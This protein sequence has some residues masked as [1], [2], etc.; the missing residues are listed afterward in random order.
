[1]PSSRTLVLGAACAGAVVALLLLRKRLSA[2]SWT[3]QDQERV[4]AHLE[5]F[6][7][8][9]SAGTAPAAGTAGL[10]AEE[11]AFIDAQIQKADEEDMLD[12]ARQAAY[13]P[14]SGTTP[15]P[16]RPKGKGFGKGK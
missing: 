3:S 12:D 6:A 4:D 7:A 5:G 16:S 11:Q 9:A 15:D 8:G 14:G 13:P 1:M 10:S 2:G